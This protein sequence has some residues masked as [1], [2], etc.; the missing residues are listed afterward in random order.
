RL[1]SAKCRG[2]H[3]GELSLRRSQIAKSRR[4]RESALLELS[5]QR[6]RVTVSVSATVRNEDVVPEK[7]ASSA[8]EGI[9]DRMGAA[10]EESCL[11]AATGMSGSV[12][13]ELRD[14]SRVVRA[15]G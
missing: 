15:S 14:T 9:H 3:R 1:L 4:A 11:G 10:A 2:E 12:A 13:A 6:T 7:I 5:R 8:G